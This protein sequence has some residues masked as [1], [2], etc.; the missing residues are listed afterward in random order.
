[1]KKVIFGITGLAVILSF[2]AGFGLAEAQNKPDLDLFDC[3]QTHGEAAAAHRTLNGEIGVVVEVLDGDTIKVAIGGNASTIHLLGVDAPALDEH[4]GERA[5]DMLQREAPVGSPVVVYAYHGPRFG[6]RFG[7]IESGVRTR[8]YLNDVRGAL[9][10]F[11]VVTRTTT[12]GPYPFMAAGGCLAVL[13][14]DAVGNKFGLWSEGTIP[15]AIPEEKSLEAY[16]AEHERHTE[17]DCP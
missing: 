13:Q 9:L 14:A 16:V 11:G 4:L 6:H 3:V 5:R 7:V 15:S 10:S 12:P 17:D 1:M 2:I 8:G